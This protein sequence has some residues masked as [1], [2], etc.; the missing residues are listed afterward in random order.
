MKTL[1]QLLDQHQITNPTDRL[2]FEE[3]VNDVT[4]ASAAEMQTVNL[5]AEKSISDAKQEAQNQVTAERAANEA[6]QTELA[7]LR[8]KTSLAVKTASEA[9]NDTALDD[10]ATLA[11]LSAVISDVT[12]DSRQREREA[13]E[14]SIA[15]QQ[16]Q[17]AAMQ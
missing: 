11:V 16:A 17:L 8:E 9:I 15:A 1:I 7:A 2:E 10:K 4:R 13:L 5:S 12:K 14:T 6:L 3:V